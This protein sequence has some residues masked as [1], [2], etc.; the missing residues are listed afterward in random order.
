MKNYK[1][2]IC[3]AVA[4]ILSA[5][6][7]NFL[8]K[9]PL[10]QVSSQTFWNDESDAYLGLMGV[11][12]RLQLNYYG[13]NRYILD[14][15]TDNGFQKDNE[16][17]AADISQGNIYPTTGGLVSTMYSGGYRGISACNIFLGNVK[18]VEM[19]AG[20]K[21]QYIAEA[22]FLRAWFYFNLQQFYGDVIIYEIPPTVESSK[23]KQSTGEQVLSFV[24]QDLD[25]S[26]TDLPDNPYTGRIVKNSALALKA[27][28]LLYQEKWSEAASV[29][30]QI[31][32]SGKTSLSNDFTGLFIT[33]GQDLNPSEILFSSRYL[34]P[35]NY[36]EYAIRVAWYGNHNPRQELVDDYECADGLSV[37]QSPLY[38]PYHPY[39]NRDSRLKQTVQVEP[40][41]V[42]G[43]V[44]QQE[45]SVTGYLIQ[46][47]IDKEIGQIGYA[48]RSDNDFIHLRYADVL[49]MYAEAR[50]EANGPDESVHNAINAIRARSGMP[51]VAHDL[52][53]DAMRERIRHE[54][55]IELA[56]EGHRYFDIKRWKIAPQVMAAV[57][58]PGKGVGVLNFE[59]HH[60]VWPFPQ[61][62]MDIN[63]ELDQK[64]GYE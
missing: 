49:L 29:A 2:F 15:I 47:G 24:L 50:N 1:L 7:G 22:K 23:I 41:V 16:G 63:P 8:E 38:D 19:D 13:Y 28:V 27:K 34:N 21:K 55:R 9:N 14:F 51:A 43:Q 44:I 59:S 37:S 18:D 25:Q 11:Y 42:D 12:S 45:E 17:S 32:S 60:Y 58:E 39:L 10:D 61:S 52:S 33:K 6:E 62:E 57:D 4:L 20:V 35:D 46:K 36:S 5:C 54:R 64:A 30:S 26:I 56:F 3:F 40:W 31:M 53:K 48:T